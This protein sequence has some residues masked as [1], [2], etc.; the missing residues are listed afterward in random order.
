MILDTRSKLLSGSRIHCGESLS[1]QVSSL[2]W[3]AA[4]S[5]MMVY[6]VRSWARFLSLGW[7]TVPSEGMLAMAK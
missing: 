5:W 2:I 7:V 4:S 3:V 1:G 6:L